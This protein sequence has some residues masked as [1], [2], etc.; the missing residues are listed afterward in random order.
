MFHCKFTRSE[1]AKG[2]LLTED[3]LH[4]PFILLGFERACGVNQ[5]PAR[6]QRRQSAFRSIMACNFARRVISSGRRRHLIS[7]LRAKVPVPEQGASSKIRSNFAPK[8]SSRAASNRTI[9]K[10][11]A[12]G[13]H[14]GQKFGQRAKR[15][16][17]WSQATS[18]P[19]PS[20][21]AS[22]PA[23][24]PGAA[25]RSRHVLARLG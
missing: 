19:A 20:I 1:D 22:C 11:T 14:C 17:L 13:T 4:H 10:R 3:P 9:D 2:R 21:C 12:A 24:I 5:L 18:V 16:A 15:A 25:H 6:R 8:G 7:G 23:F